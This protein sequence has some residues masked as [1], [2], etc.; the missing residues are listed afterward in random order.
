MNAD[1]STLINLT[2]HPADDWW[3][4]W[5]LNGSQ[6]TYP[7]TRSGN[8]KISMINTDSEGV[9]Y[10]HNNPVNEWAVARRT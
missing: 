4:A 6:I 1:G 7:S 2:N 9:V 3:T 5:S 10:F 8:M